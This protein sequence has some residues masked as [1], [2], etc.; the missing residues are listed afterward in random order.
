MSSFLKKLA[1]VISPNLGRHL[2]NKQLQR[3]LHAP[4]SFSSDNSVRFW[5]KMPYENYEPSVTKVLQN[6]SE[7]IDVFV[8]VGANSGIFCLK[9]GSY[10]Q[11]IYAFEPLNDNLKLLMKNIRENHLD[12]KV[13]IFPMA[14]GAKCDIVDFFGASTA[15]S[16]LKGWNFQ[17]DKGQMVPCVSLDSILL[18]KLLKKRALFLID[19]EGAE[20]D[21]VE[22]AQNIIS[23]T[24]SV[25]C[26][27]IP[28]REFMPNEIFNPN[29]KKIFDLF[30]E[31]GY[32][33]W[34]IKEDAGL[35]KL[36][37]AV[38]NEYITSQRYYGVMA[39]FSRDEIS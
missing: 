27:E 31:F 13:T 15:G 34:E 9:L 11:R 18:D 36:G 30:K 4:P 32:T 28:C 12:K 38:I 25:F 20:F 24:N 1:N 33:S 14:V 35:V 3:I 21:V 6:I 7:K 22:G 5:G 10:M 17:V 23:S 19:V 29:F 16:L 8:N 2:R 39:L 26:I 37:D